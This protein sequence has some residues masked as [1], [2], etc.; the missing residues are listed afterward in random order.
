MAWTISLLMMNQA[1]SG[2]PPLM[3]TIL[4]I[5]RQQAE[6]MVYNAP[7]SL[8]DGRVRAG[9][10]NRLQCSY[11]FTPLGGDVPSLSPARQ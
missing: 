9:V 8:Q 6:R 3:A 10:L 7:A 5:R 1:K 11:E 2:A 4:R